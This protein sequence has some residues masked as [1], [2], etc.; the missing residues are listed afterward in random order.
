MEGKYQSQ[1]TDMKFVN[2]WTSDNSEFWKFSNPS[3]RSFAYFID[4][5]FCHTTNRK[6]FSVYS[7][8]DL[9][10]VNQY[11]KERFIIKKS[12]VWEKN[13]NLIRY[14]AMMSYSVELSGKVPHMNKQAKNFLFYMFSCKSLYFSNYEVSLILNFA[15]YSVWCLIFTMVLDTHVWHW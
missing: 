6:L 13:L 14:Q 5:L 3:S 10:Y 4:S 12:I 8:M 7:Y 15:L 11:Y 2:F 1:K 9:H